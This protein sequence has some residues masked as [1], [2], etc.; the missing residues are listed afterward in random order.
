MVD[1]KRTDTQEQMVGAAREFGRG[2]VAPAEIEL[3]LVA[4]PEEVFAS[5]RYWSV[6]SQFFELGFNRMALPEEFG[7]L[8]LDPQTTG[9]VWEELARW[10]PGFAASLMP[11]AVGP[12][13]AVL[14]GPGPQGPDRRIRASVLRGQDRPPDHCLVQLRARCRLRRQQLRRPRRP[15]PHRRPTRRRQVHPERSQVRLRLQRRHRQRLHRVRLRRPVHGHQ[16][17]GR[18]R[19][20]WRRQGP[21]PRQSHRQDRTAD[22][23]PVLGVL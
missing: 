6:M 16:G 13:A 11:G 15:S 7:G 14:P 17:L 12:P 22:T 18:L 9:M 20:P 1:F 5:E 23:Q 8:G 21:L 3:D 4:D 19:G 2:A 10:G